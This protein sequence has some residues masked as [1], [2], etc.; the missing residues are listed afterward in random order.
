MKKNYLFFLGCIASSLISNAQIVNGNFETWTPTTWEDLDT[1]QTSNTDAIGNGKPANATKVSPAQN[2]NYAIKLETSITGTDTNFAYILFGDF[3]DNGP[4]GGFPYTQKPTTING[5]YKSNFVTG[6]SAAI[7]VAFRKGG[8]AVTMDLFKIGTTQSAFTAFSFPLSIATYSVNPDS[9]ILVIASSTPKDI[10]PN[11][12]PKNGTWIIL[13]NISFGGTGITQQIPNTNFE[14]WSTISIEDPQGWET[15]NIQTYSYFGQQTYA[16]KT[17]DKYK[18]SYALELTTI[19]L[20]SNANIASVTNGHVASGGG[21]YLGGVPFTNQIDTLMGYYKYTPSGVDTG[22]I[23]LEFRKNGSSIY[24]SGT[25]LLPAASYTYFEIPVNLS[26]IPDTV[27]IDLSSSGWPVVASNDGS[28]LIIDEI[29]WKSAPLNTGI[30]EAGSKTFKSIAFPN[31]AYEHIDIAVV[32]ENPSDMELSIYDI[33]GKLVYNNSR[34]GYPQGKNVIRINTGNLPA[35][36]YT[37]TLLT[38]E[39]NLSSGKFIVE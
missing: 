29:Q 9:V 27:R 19:Y 35:G 7:I 3:G 23:G 20:D 18:G 37:Y 36:T 28:M 15:F 13:D 10:D 31:P 12:T 30:L 38:G 39:Q 22:A 4:E 34:N 5:Y 16:D 8:V 11:A 32:L 1:A 21:G 2:G 26:Q 25:W 6:D 17:T 14:L 33:Y 24:Y